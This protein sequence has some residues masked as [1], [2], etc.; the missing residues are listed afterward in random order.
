MRCDG[1][2]RAVAHACVFAAHGAMKQMCRGRRPSTTSVEQEDLFGL[3]NG[4]RSDWEIIGEEEEASLVDEWG[5]SSERGR[6]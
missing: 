3:I 2:M 4:N 6:V 5:V 1:A